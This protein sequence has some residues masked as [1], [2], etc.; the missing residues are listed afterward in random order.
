M[1]RIRFTKNA[2]REEQRKLVQFERYL[3][4]LQLKKA[5][6]QMEVNAAYLEMKE[7]EKKK[8]E[9]LQQIYTF[10]SLFSDQSECDALAYTEIKHVQKNYE[11]IAG[12]DVPVFE[13]LLFTEKT[14]SL[15]DTPAWLDQA[16]NSVKEYLVFKEELA[17]LVEKKGALEKEL[18]DVSI[19][20][21]L[22]EKI[23]IPR[24]RENIK[25]IKVFLSDQELAAIAQAKVAKMKM[26]KAKA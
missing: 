1:A 24:S 2:L 25:K 21:N 14:Y 8:E 17:V 26:E 10:A 4:T 7:I 12:V 3:P 15:F 5:L 18:K 11:N 23:L 13:D 19:R 22:F 16:Q 20:V 9:L 6:L